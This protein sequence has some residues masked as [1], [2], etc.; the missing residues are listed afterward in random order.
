MF[1]KPRRL[2]MLELSPKLRNQP[3]WRYYTALNARVQCRLE[4]ELGEMLRTAVGGVRADS[5]SS[6]S[7]R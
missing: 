7:S 3:A 4:P 6:S 2:G 5:G 1:S